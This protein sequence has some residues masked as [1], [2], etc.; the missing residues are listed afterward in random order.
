[1]D[2]FI[3]EHIKRLDPKDARDMA[4]LY[5]IEHNQQ[6]FSFEVRILIFAI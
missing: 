6:S 5:L 3:D 1:M 2:T 4:D